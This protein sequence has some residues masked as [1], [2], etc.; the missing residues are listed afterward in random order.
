MKY[1]ELRTELIRIFNNNNFIEMY[2]NRKQ[3]KLKFNNE[4]NYNIQI[5]YPGYKTKVEGQTVKAY[6]FRVDYENIAISHA[7]IVVDLY[8]KVVQAPFLKKELLSFIN[9]LGKTGMEIELDKY[10]KIHTYN[11]ISPSNNL[12]LHINDVHRSLNK[13][14]LIEGNRKNYSISELSILIPLIVLQE[15]INY[16]MPKYQGRKMSFYRYI[17]SISCDNVA[18]LYEVIRRTLSHTRPILFEGIDY[19]DIVELSNYV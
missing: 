14:Y 11:F 7:N 10:E 18:Q 17:E 9:E 8:N 6:D 4:Y 1:E 3:R 13:K 12:L 15:D 19:K 2:K 16:P 5:I